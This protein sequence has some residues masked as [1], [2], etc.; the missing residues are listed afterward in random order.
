MP[1]TIGMTVETTCTERERQNRDVVGGRAYVLVG[2]ALA[3]AGRESDAQQAYEAGRAAWDERGLHGL[4]AQH[5]EP[6]LV[7]LTAQQTQA[8]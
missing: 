7:A 2:D 8:T 6:R 4:V 5:I 1:S 3:A